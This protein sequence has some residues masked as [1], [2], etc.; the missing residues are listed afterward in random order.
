MTFAVLI[1]SGLASTPSS[2]TWSP[3]LPSIC[4]ASSMASVV[5]GQTV[6]H[7]ES[8]K[9]SST[10]LPRNWLSDMAWPNWLVSLTLGAA[11]RPSEV[12][13]SRLGLDA[14]ALELGEAA[15]WLALP[16]LEQPARASAAATTAPAAAVST[17]SRERHPGLGESGEVNLATMLPRLL[18]R[19]VA[20]DADGVVVHV[21]LPAVSPLAAVPAGRSMD[22]E[23]LRGTAPGREAAGSS[24][25]DGSSPTMTVPPWPQVM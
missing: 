12:P 16:P 8:T 14:A 11:G 15:A 2:C 6:V 21:D 20:S 7:S 19:V 17:R 3:A 22:S 13:R 24:L 9:L 18:R 25:W 23:G 5:S 4:L 1:A 10:A